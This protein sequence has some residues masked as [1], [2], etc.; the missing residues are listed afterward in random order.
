ME[1]INKLAFLNTAWINFTRDSTHFLIKFNWV[2]FLRKKSL[3]HIQCEQM[4]II[5]C[6]LF[7]RLKQLNFSRLHKI[8]QSWPK[9]LP[10]TK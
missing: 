9:M 6:S 3:F 5:I 7:G 4:A 1:R 2:N 10:I 8:C